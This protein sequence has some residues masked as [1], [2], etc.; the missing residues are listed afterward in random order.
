M[1]R[2]L[3][4]PMFRLGGNTDQGIMSGVAPR[5]GYGYGERVGENTKE[6]AA[7][8]RKAV[9]Q[10]PDTSLS[11]FMIDFGLDIASRPPQGSIFST[12]AAAAKEPYQGYKASK[13]A[14]GTFDQKIGLAAAESAMGHEDRM[15][16]IALKNLSKDER[17]MME[18]RAQLLVDQGVV[19]N[20]ADGLRR[21]L[22]K[23]TEDPGEARKKGIEEMG[24]DEYRKFNF[25]VEQ[26]MRI[27]GVDRKTAEAA[28]LDTQEFSKIGHERPE[29][30]RKA[31]ID[32]IAESIAERDD[33][34][35]TAA[36]PIAE[37]IQNA[38]EGKFDTE[39]EDAKDQISGR[40]D[41]NQLYIIESD[42]GE[43]QGDDTYGVTT[44]M[45]EGDYETNKVY[46]NPKDGSFYWYDGNKR[47]FN[48]VVLS[49]EEAMKLAPTFK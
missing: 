32:K 6:R 7:I 34:M 42:I 41:R 24:G 25:K 16:E 14:R 10:T 33:I 3:R 49:G 15:L 18:K 29:V 45:P 23:K 47:Q 21:E 5:Q 1:T 12:A 40:L 44:D 17:I 28:I 36:T 31:E 20:L 8:L 46:Y 38:I 37:A 48:L 2:T 43:R 19:D 4:R 39:G 22:Y 9:G 27:R 11:Q 30:L 26:Y 35:I 13:A